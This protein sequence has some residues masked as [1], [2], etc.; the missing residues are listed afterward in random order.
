MRKKILGTD[1]KVSAIGFG[2]MGMIQI[3]KR[4][5]KIKTLPFLMKNFVLYRHTV[6]NKSIDSE[7][8]QLVGYFDDLF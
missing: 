3:Q 2:C 1:L 5:C 4:Q 8:Q 6:F 7:T